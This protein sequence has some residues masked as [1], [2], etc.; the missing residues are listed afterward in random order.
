MVTLTV[1]RVW[2]TIYSMLRNNSQSIEV[3]AL[4][5]DLK[6]SRPSGHV[7]YVITTKRSLDYLLSCKHLFVSL[8]S[9]S[10]AISEPASD[11][12]NSLKLLSRSQ[13]VMKHLF[14]CRFLLTWDQRLGSQQKMVYRSL[15]CSFTEPL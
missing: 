3:K 5:N 1:K 10:T 2:L 7:T 11:A 14:T 9:V 12:D 4:K 13:A 15:P 8:G 6:Y